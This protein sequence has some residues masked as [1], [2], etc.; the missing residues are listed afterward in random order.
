MYSHDVFL[1]IVESRC[2]C[3]VAF[4]SNACDAWRRSR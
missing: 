2:I 4:R 1:A 3:G